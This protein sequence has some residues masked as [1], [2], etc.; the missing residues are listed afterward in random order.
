MKFENQYKMYGFFNLF[1]DFLTCTLYFSSD[2]SCFFTL[3]FAASD[4]YRSNEFQ[5]TCAF[6]WFSA[7]FTIALFAF[8]SI[9][10]L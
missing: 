3:F 5:D 10:L 1:P 8:F 9:L 2:D 6:L 7:I 4:A